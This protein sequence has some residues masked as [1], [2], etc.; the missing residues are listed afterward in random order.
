MKAVSLF[1][2]RGDGAV[3]FNNSIIAEQN[4][5]I[6]KVEAFTTGRFGNRRRCRFITVAGF[7]DMAADRV[8]MKIYLPVQLIGN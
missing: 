5:V 7:A 2:S 8:T 6:K 4:K 3:K 1:M